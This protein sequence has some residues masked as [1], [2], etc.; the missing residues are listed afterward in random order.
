MT[1]PSFNRFGCIP[2]RHDGWAS[3]GRLPGVPGI[4]RVDGLVNYHVLS[5]PP[6][7]RAHAPG[8]HVSHAICC[9]VYF[10]PEF[11][12]PCVMSSFSFST[13][14]LIIVVPV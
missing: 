13:F 2:P 14:F 10:L 7:F 4:S 8:I 9:Y 1:S 11:T 6:L 3:A 12:Q 5:D